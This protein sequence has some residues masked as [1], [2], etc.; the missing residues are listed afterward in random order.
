M[1]IKSLNVDSFHPPQPPTSPLVRCKATDCKPDKRSRA[2]HLDNRADPPRV[3]LN[4]AGHRPIDLSRVRPLRGGADAGAGLLVYSR[5]KV[6]AIHSIIVFT[7]L[8]REFS[9]SHANDRA[10]PNF[11]MV[12]RALDFCSCSYVSRVAFPRDVVR[13]AVMDA[14]AYFKPPF[15]ETIRTSLCVWHPSKR[16]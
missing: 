15:T 7:A 9:I 5:A 2:H 3:R 10:R 6:R 14:V 16:V 13:V 12:W 11:I 8:E 4:I 1:C